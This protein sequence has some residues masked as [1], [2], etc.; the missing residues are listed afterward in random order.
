MQ[1]ENHLEKHLHETDGKTLLFK[2]LQ[3][4]SF[5][6]FVAFFLYRQRPLMD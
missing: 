4:R 1:T 5:C 6:N 2:I 3:S